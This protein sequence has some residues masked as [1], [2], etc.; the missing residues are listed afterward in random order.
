MI[1]HQTISP[2][3]N[4]CIAL[5]RSSLA[6]RQDN[7]DIIPFL[8]IS[9]RCIA[10]VLSCDD[11]LYYAGIAHDQYNPSETSAPRAKLSL[12]WTEKHSL[13]QHQAILR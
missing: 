3:L 5:P 11:R 8:H 12:E 13:K 7:L 9:T 1:W 6:V 2:D 4:A 10:P